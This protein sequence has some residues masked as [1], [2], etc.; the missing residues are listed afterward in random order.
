MLALLFSAVPAMP[1]HASGATD[2]AVVFS[3]EAAEVHLTFIAVGDRNQLI[4]DLSRRD[5]K[6]LRDGAPVENITSF[7]IL[8]DAP[9]SLVILADV[10]ESMQKSIPFE[11]FAKAYLSQTLSTN[12]DQVS[13]L[14][15]GASVHPTGMAGRPNAHLTSMYDSALDTVLHR[16]PG[17]ARMAILVISDGGDNYSLHSAED[18]IT[19]AQQSD[20]AFYVLNTD[21]GNENGC[22]NLRTLAERTGGRFYLLRKRKDLFPAIQEIESD[23]RNTYMIT[24]RAEGARHGLHEL[25]LAPAGRSLRFFYRTAYYQ[26]ADSSS[27]GASLVAA[28]AP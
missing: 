27:R 26:P 1:G 20:V 7:E 13:F 18:V 11:N 8:K 22:R 25:T 9:L 19:A 28:A 17:L 12:T 21:P 6:L 16:Q 5:F 4:T 2:S 24:F 10:S 15:F 23:L 3:A 14:D